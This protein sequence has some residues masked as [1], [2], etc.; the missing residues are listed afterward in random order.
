MAFNHD[1]TKIV[2]GSADGKV[3]VWD[4]NTGQQ[5]GKALQHQDTVY[6]VAFNNDCTKIVSGIAMCAG[7]FTHYFLYTFSRRNFGDVYCKY[8]SAHCYS[9]DKTVQVWDANTGQQIGKALKYEDSVNSVAFNHDSTK[10]VS[11][12]DDKTMRVWDI[13]FQGLVVRVCEQLRY[14]PIRTYAKTLYIAYVK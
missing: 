8:L 4:V 7:I 13:S 2:S 14:H 5:I 1:G 10:I 6:S 11:G 12:S 3:H 9:N